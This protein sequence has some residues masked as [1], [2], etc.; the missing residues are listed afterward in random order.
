VA[1]PVNGVAPSDPRLLRL[2]D[3]DN[4]LIVIA[5]I[6]AGEWFEVEGVTVETPVPLPLGFKVAAVDLE[7]G[8]EAIRYG[9][10]I[11]RTTRAVA[12]GE[13]VHTDNLASTY[14]RTHAR[15]EA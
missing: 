8:A 4:V 3:G 7:D 10:P 5:A 6:G 15:G 12:R 14:M 11:G 13:L 9:M 1:R 2:A